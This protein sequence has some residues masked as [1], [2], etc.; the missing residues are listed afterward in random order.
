MLE[1]YILNSSVHSTYLQA[2]Q[3]TRKPRKTFMLYIFCNV[4]GNVDVGHARLGKEVGEDRVEA[5]HVEQ[6]H[7]VVSLHLLHVCHVLTDKQIKS[8]DILTR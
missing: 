5:D 6:V 1:K 8:I 2:I 3:R 4:P 7:S